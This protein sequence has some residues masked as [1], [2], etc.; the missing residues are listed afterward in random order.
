MA[1]SPYF[2]NSHER[3]ART[4]EI[5]YMRGPSSETG[6]STW[7]PFITLCMFQAA[8]VILHSSSRWPSNYIVVF[9]SNSLKSWSGP[10]L[11]IITALGAALALETWSSY[12]HNRCRHVTPCCARVLKTANARVRTRDL[13]SAS[14]CTRTRSTAAASGA[15]DSVC[16]ACRHHGW[17]QTAHRPPPPPPAVCRTAVTGQMRC[18]AGGGAPPAAFS[19]PTSDRQTRGDQRSNRG[20]RGPHRAT[21]LR[22]MI[23]EKNR[24]LWLCHQTVNDNFELSVCS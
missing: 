24:L 1:R 16:G 11:L 20:R 17:P 14:V 18:L 3:W 22:Q 19:R 12:D 23:G 10:R 2:S 4:S 9:G 6:I 8:P 15:R 13:W 21:H 7:E 5:R